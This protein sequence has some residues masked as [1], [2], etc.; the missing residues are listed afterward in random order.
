MSE[1]RTQIFDGLHQSLETK[2]REKSIDLQRVKKERKTRDFDQVK[3]VKDEEDKVLVQENDIKD[4]WKMYFYNLFNEA[5]DISPD[6]NKFNIIEEYRNY[7]Y[8]CGIQKQE[9]K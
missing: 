6:S 9:V 7:N 1:A 5:Y 2:K 8:Y 3:R 4:R